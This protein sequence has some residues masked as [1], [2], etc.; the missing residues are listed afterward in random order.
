MHDVRDQLDFGTQSIVTL[1]LPFASTHGT[2]CHVISCLLNKELEESTG[3]A[4]VLEIAFL[5]THL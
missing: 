3:L 2:C 1:G 4:V 5:G